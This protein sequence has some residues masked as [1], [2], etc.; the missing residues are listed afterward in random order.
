MDKELELKQVLQDARYEINSLR[1]ANELLK[2]NPAV[3]G[4]TMCVDV[5]SAIDKKIQE[6]DY[7][8][9]SRLTVRIS[10]EEL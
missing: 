2:T 8:I 3:S 4:N 1:R 7:E 6:L 9:K 10:N 5:T